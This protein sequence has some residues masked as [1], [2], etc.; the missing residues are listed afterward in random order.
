[1]QVKKRG[2]IMSRLI[3]IAAVVAVVLGMSLSI[4]N[5]N[6]DEGVEETPIVATATA[7]AEITGD[8]VIEVPEVEATEVD[9]AAKGK[10]PE[11]KPEAAVQ[12]LV[13]LESDY[14]ILEKDVLA[15]D[16]RQPDRV[17]MRLSE[18]AAAARA[19]QLK[20]KAKKK[21]GEA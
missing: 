17:T 13:S 3:A 21:G 15:I 4:A 2:T 6:T 20:S 12:R 11:T 16:L 14:R 8:P 1:M 9:S 19:D 10:K 7:T 5:A 18:E